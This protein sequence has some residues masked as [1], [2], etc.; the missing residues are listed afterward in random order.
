M[1]TKDRDWGHKAYLNQI[2]QDHAA[3][4]HGGTMGTKDFDAQGQQDKAAS[5]AKKKAKGL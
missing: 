3:G 5:A 4:Q 1:P 2:E